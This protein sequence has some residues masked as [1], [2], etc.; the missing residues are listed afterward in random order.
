MCAWES[1]QI[2]GCTYPE[3]PAVGALPRGT[4][5]YM[6]PFTYEIR[7]VH[8]CA[9]PGLQ[10]ISRRRSSFLYAR[11]IVDLNKYAASCRLSFPYLRFLSLSP[12]STTGIV[13][14]CVGL[15]VGYIPG[16]SIGRSYA[17]LD[18]ESRIIPASGS[19]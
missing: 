10:F 19:N 13:C 14:N 17:L 2:R 1:A 5:H 4:G 12:S 6:Y 11:L 15:R 3:K 18:E 16:S 9:G 8:I 7:A